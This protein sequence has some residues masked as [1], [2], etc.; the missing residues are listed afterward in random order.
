MPG[1]GPIAAPSGISVHVYMDITELCKITMWITNMFYS[2]HFRL[3]SYD[4]NADFGG[5][6][7]SSK[8]EM[9]I[10]DVEFRDINTSSKVICLFVHLLFLFLISWHQV[11]KKWNFVPLCPL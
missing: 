6:V 10:P 9:T 1:I 4:R 3:E 8:W 11:L 2:F 7:E 5:R